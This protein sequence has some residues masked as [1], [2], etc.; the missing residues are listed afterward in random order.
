VVIDEAHN[1]VTSSD[2]RKDFQTMLRQTFKFCKL[3]LL[4]G[5]LTTEVQ[6]QLREHGLSHHPDC[7]RAFDEQIQ[8]SQSREEIYTHFQVVTSDQNFQHLYWL[9]SL[10]HNYRLEDLS[11]FP[12]ILIYVDS[13]ANGRLVFNWLHKYC[14]ERFRKRIMKYHAAM[15]N[16]ESKKETTRLFRT[17]AY[18]I[19]VATKLLGE[20][21]NYPSLRVTILQGLRQTNDLFFTRMCALLNLCLTY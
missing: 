2:F 3:V 18:K 6:M 7:S 16:D 14:P 9:I 20:G 4:S 12:Q 13:H 8:T 19:L 5:S 15:G 1:L 21:V 10:M 17:G 11:D